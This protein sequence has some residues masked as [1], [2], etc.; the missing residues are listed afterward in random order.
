MNKLRTH[1][2]LRAWRRRRAA[3][4]DDK[5]HV[6]RASRR[7]RSSEAVEPRFDEAGL[8]PVVS[9]AN[10]VFVPVGPDAKEVSDELLHL[11]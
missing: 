11:E 3:A 9:E 4:L 7:M 5:E 2:I 6:E 8:R 10:F 1:L